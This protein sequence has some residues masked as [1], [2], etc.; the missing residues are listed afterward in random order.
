MTNEYDYDIF[1][2]PLFPIPNYKIDETDKPINLNEIDLGNGL[3]FSV[4]SVCS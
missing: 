2:N 1:A 4:N 3:T